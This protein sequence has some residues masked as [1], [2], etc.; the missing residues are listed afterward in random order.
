MNLKI[1]RII[2]AILTITTFATIFIFSSQ[3]GNISGDTSRGFT[4]K[5]VEILRIDKNLSETEK[6]NLIEN[7]QFIIRKLTHFTI[8]TIAGINIFGF[9]NTFDM[10][11]KNKI[12]CALFTGAVYAMTDEF[13]QMFSGERTASPKDVCI[14]SV[15]VLFGVCIYLIVEKIIKKIRHKQLK[16]NTKSYI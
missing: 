16:N 3:N 2:F 15:G 8:Y 5:I 10:K 14:D 4:R 12:I 7:S 9:F 11:M 6:E 13:H 1:Q